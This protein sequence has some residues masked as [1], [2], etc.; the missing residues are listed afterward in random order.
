[1]GLGKIIAKWTF[2]RS[3]PDKKRVE[4][5]GLDSSFES[6]SRIKLKMGQLKSSDKSK[7]KQSP[8]TEMQNSLKQEILQLEKR[9]QD[10]FQVRHALENALGYKT[11]SHDSTTELSMPKVNSCHNDFMEIEIVS[12][13]CHCHSK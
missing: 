13:V 5:D 12:R 11:S 9:L 8:K 3:L 10:Q 6:S 1:M 2:G 7:K 4:E